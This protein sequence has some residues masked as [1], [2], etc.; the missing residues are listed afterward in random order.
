MSGVL[1]SSATAANSIATHEAPAPETENVQSA[2]PLGNQITALDI[3]DAVSQ[4]AP[5]GAE[6]PR[7]YITGWRLYVLTFG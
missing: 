3:E 4:A 6:R 5:G 1:E 7:V 2:P